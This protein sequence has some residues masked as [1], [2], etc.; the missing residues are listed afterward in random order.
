MRK[1]TW[2]NCLRLPE[3]R[4]YIDT[5]TMTDHDEQ[6]DIAL[7]ATWEKLLSS[8]GAAPDV[9]AA[10]FAALERRYSGPGRVY[11]TLQHVADV[12]QW[13]STLAAYST[14]P[15]AVQLAGWFH[16][17]VYNPRRQDNEEES[18]A[19]AGRQL[20]ASAVPAATIAEVQRLIRLSKNHQPAA[21]DGNGQVLADAD[22][23]ILG[24]PPAVYDRY[25]RAIRQEYGWLEDDP[26]RRGR[27]QVLR[28]F[29]Q[30]EH[31]YHTPPMRKQWEAAARRNLADELGHL[32]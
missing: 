30:R 4:P 7:Q 18:A 10:T 28:H 27:A 17:A 12:L 2:G 31:I 23:A 24:A 16:D 3:K 21:G 8:F 5:V 29:L 26:Y 13:A 25:A 9:C 19:Y 20:A 15:R 22:L 32:T 11:H 14:A 6:H 1:A